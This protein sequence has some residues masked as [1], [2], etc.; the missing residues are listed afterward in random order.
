MSS[1]IGWGSHAHDIEAVTP[2]TRH[3][4][5]HIDWL[6]C[7][8]SDEFVTIGINDP[9]VR[10]EVATWLRVRDQRW[11]HPRAYLGIDSHIGHGTHVNYGVTMT[12]T[13]VGEHCTI[14]P[15]VTICGDVLIGDR[16]LIGAGAVVCDRVT[17]GNDATIGAGAVVLPEAFVRE[18]ETWVGVPAKA[19]RC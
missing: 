14:S 19:N 2:H 16:V 6:D 13:I 10:A 1:L 18:G 11:V 15:G 7:G 3:F 8:A 12:R 5:D 17:I 4:C 9:R